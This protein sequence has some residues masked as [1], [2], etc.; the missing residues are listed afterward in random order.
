MTLVEG[1]F[2]ARGVAVALGLTSAGAPQVAVELTIKDEEFLGETITW[3]G[4]FT[5]K[6]TERT[7]ETLRNLVG[8][9]MT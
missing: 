3:F 8:R 6:T 7:L 5:E 9:P 1:T 2:V 4:Y